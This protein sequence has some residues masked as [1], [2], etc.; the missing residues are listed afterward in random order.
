MPV[1]VRANDC[2]TIQ[3]YDKIYFLPYRM[4]QRFDL[5]ANLPGLHEVTLAYNT[6]RN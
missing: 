3:Q 6:H 5:E 1:P 4:F 2:Q